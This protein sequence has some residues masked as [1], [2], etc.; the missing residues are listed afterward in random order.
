MKEVRGTGIPSHKAKRNP[1]LLHFL[2][3]TFSYWLWIQ[4]WTWYFCLMKPYRKECFFHLSSY[5][6]LFISSTDTFAG[7]ST[8]T[9]THRV[10]QSTYQHTDP[11][12]PFAIFHNH[13][14]HFQKFSVAFVPFSSTYVGTIPGSTLWKYQWYLQVCTSRDDPPGTPH[15]ADQPY[16]LLCSRDHC[17]NPG[18]L[19]WVWST[20]STACFPYQVRSLLPPKHLS[21]LPLPSLHLAHTGT[22][23][24]N[25]QERQDSAEQLTV[26]VGFY[27]F[28]LRLGPHRHLVLAPTADIANR[29][30]TA[31]H[32]IWDMGQILLI[33][34]RALLFPERRKVGGTEI[35]RNGTEQKPNR[36]GGGKYAATGRS[37]TLM[38]EWAWRTSQ[39]WQ[40]WQSLS[41]LPSCTSGRHRWRGNEGSWDE[42]HLQRRSEHAK[43]QENFSMP[44]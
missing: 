10:S 4:N 42:C 22:P 39:R 19:H 24:K 38:L 44:F 33:H 40:R 35:C 8:L 20:T 37:H 15:S 16:L 41:S 18:E 29:D 34:R 7:G 17:T 27:P 1:G 6:W 9:R 36:K 26:L 23:P 14:P 12:H 2:S 31:L 30:S 11:A 32:H 43:R 13:L 28:L 21:S 3:L 25:S 5:S